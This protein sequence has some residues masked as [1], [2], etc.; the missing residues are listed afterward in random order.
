[1]GQKV[2]VRDQQL[3]ITNLEID[4]RDVV[5]FFASVPEEERESRFIH[6]VELGVFCLQRTTLHSDADFFKRQLT[7]LV[8]DVE[9]LLMVLP[10][11]T[12]AE[13]VKKIGTSD[14]QVLAPIK[15][16]VDG[17]FNEGRRRIRE[18]RTLLEGKLDPD[19]NKS[20]LGKA[21]GEVR[22]M[23]N[24]NHK[25]S[26]QSR[27]EHAVSDITRNNGPLV[28]AVRTV[29][30]EIT[31]P[32]RLDVD[33][34]TAELR[35]EE[36]S[37]ALKQRTTLKGEQFQEEVLA[38]LS[39]WKRITGA[40]VEYC[41]KDNRPGDFVITLPE[42]VLEK[43]YVIAVEAKSDGE[44]R[45]RKRIKD[46][47]DRAMAH[48]RAEAAV[49]VTKTLD[50]LAEEIGEWYEGS[51]SRGPFVACTFNHLTTALRLLMVQRHIQEIRAILP[52]VDRQTILAEI[53]RIRTALSKITTIRKQASTIEKSTTTIKNE[54]D[55]L[56]QEIQEAL[57]KIDRSIQLANQQAQPKKLAA[58]AAG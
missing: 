23:V 38:E 36:V 35:G 45:G 33:R 27:L 58:R 26:I 15:Q 54:A 9:K 42:G 47:L 53:D 11:R 10:Q 32:L 34:L 19:N 3:H 43:P 2:V 39:D 4:R 29:V 6:A 20:T 51:S 17:V 44:E 48:R 56:Q 37:D 22:Q 28:K 1:M 7:T 16:H 31:E 8:A 14:G 57:T 25:N 30:T 52:D 18:I 55:A 12:E 40:D 46:S 49:F 24:P 21:L 41:A 50:G 13:L 5:D